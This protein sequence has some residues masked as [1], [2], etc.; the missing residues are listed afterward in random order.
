MEYQ[1]LLLGTQFLIKSKYYNWFETAILGT[2]N[3]NKRLLTMK[4]VAA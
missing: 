3:I 1:K 2:S 4:I